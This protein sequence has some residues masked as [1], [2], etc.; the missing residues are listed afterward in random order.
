MQI[1]KEM[2]SVSARPPVLDRDEVWSAKK[3]YRFFKRLQDIVLSILGMIVLSPVTLIVTLVVFIECPK[4]SPIFVQD[5]VG[6]NGKKFRFYK[7]R[8]MI[9]N[10]EKGLDSLLDQNEMTGN[11]FK[12]KDDPRITKVGRFIRKLSIDELP[13][14][15]N[16]LKGDMSIVGPRPPLPREVEK[17]DEYEL[18]RLYITPGLTCYWQSTS[19]RNSFSFEDWLD[20]DIK[21][22]NER[23]FLIDWKIIIRTF[24][25]IFKMDG[26]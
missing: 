12:I 8:S 7:F 10:A 22:I 2:T 17:Y 16:V 1:I 21:Y 25:I 13:Q 11:A 23:S 5:R 14:L 20:L 4:A 9:P 24:S 18:Q 26:I 15:L 19:D 3:T 6:R